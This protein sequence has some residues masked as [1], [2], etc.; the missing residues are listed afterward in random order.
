MTAAHERRRGNQ[1]KNSV[2][3]HAAWSSKTTPAACIARST[4]SWCA[5]D[6]S[7]NGK[8]IAFPMRPIR[9]TAHLTAM[10]FASMNRSLCKAC[11]LES[12]ARALVK[13]PETAAS[14]ASRMRRGPTLAVTEMPPRAPTL[15]KSTAVGSSPDSSVNSGGQTLCISRARLNEPVASLIA[16]ICGFRANRATVGGNKSTA[17]RPGGLARRHEMPVKALLRG[18]VVVRSDEH[19]GID[20]E[21]RQGMGP[22]HRTGRRMRARSHDHL[23]PA[24][25]AYDRPA[26]QFLDFIQG[27]GRGLTGG[28]GG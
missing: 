12:I 26:G 4:A 1:H 23:D 3:T 11:R 27:Q 18:L 13:S 20:A 14:Q 9:A 5:A 16:T 8:R 17:G 21:P 7:T 2:K 25:A 10:G 19:Y 24:A 28:A 6:N 15:I 22:C